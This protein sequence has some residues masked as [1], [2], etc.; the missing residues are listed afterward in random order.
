M[1]MNIPLTFFLLCAA[2]WCMPI[3][4][5]FEGLDAYPS[6][7]PALVFAASNSQPGK[8]ASGFTDVS[9]IFTR[10][11]NKCHSGSKPAHGLRLDSYAGLMAGGWD[12]PVVVP[13]DPARSELARRIRGTSTPRMPYKGPNWLSEAETILI[14]NWIKAGAPGGNS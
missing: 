9:A 4:A 2:I 6:L 11:C 5:D 3:S 14:E 12:G 8:D 1:R 7:L 13:G 10:S